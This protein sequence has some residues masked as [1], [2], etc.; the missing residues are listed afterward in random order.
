[1]LVLSSALLIRDCAT[2]HAQSEFSITDAI[3][4]AQPNDTVI[5]PGGVYRERLLL[6]KGVNITAA[7]GEAVTIVWE[8]DQPY[9]STIQVKAG[10]SVTI[11]GVNVQ[12]TSPS[13]ANNYAVHNQGGILAMM[14]CDVT[15]AT[16][17]GVATDGGLLMLRR[18]RVHDCARNGLVCAGDLDQEAA[19]VR[20]EA[21]ESINN[22][23]NGLVALDGASVVCE[24]CTLRG[25]TLA[26]LELRDCD[27]ELKD[28]TVTGNGRA[29]I[30]TTA[31]TLLDLTDLQVDGRA[32]VN[33][34][35]PA[36]T[37]RDR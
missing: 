22:K 25:N 4:Q 2:A 10:C 15:S 5:V 28:C 3:A 27:V 21:T 29:S 11:S 33:T 17:S 31:A 23:M 16:G 7:P 13:V 34:V 37:R 14:G 19:A 30:S 24:S 1:M 6:T 36:V 12:H 35:V 8:T 20:L 9:Q 32:L 18:C 26:G